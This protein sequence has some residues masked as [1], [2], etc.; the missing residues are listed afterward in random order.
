M[1]TGS[2]STSENLP[3]KKYVKPISLHNEKYFNNNSSS[4]Q[5]SGNKSME[6][7]L[8]DLEN[9]LTT[10]TDESKN[11]DDAENNIMR[12][13]LIRRNTTG[14]IS[15]CNEKYSN[16]KSLLAQQQSMELSLS[17]FE[18]LLKDV[19]NDNKKSQNNDLLETSLFEASIGTFAIND[20]S[21]SLDN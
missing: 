12:D 10:F 5:N 3:T 9:I 2:I 18:N 14:S 15:I 6:L 20:M 7:S 16:N 19:N 21:V 17:D 13:H 1:G 11:N 8:S 4:Q